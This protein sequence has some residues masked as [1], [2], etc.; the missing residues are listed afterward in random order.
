MN[1]HNIWQAKLLKEIGVERIVVAREITYEQ[2]KKIKNE[3]DIEIETFGHGALCVSFLGNCL[4]SSFIGGRSGNRGKCAHHVDFLM[5]LV[6][7][8]V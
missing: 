3:V 2:I 7:S 1:V 4:M 5:N 8:K 6:V